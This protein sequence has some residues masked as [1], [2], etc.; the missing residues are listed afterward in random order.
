MPTSAGGRSSCTRGGNWPDLSLTTQWACREAFAAW[1]P[2][3]GVPFSYAVAVGYVLTD[4]ADKG[5]AAYRL[6]GQELG[7]NAALNPKVDLPRQAAL[8][9]QAQYILVE[10]KFNC[11]FPARC[12]LTRLLALERTLDTLVWQLLASVICPGFQQLNEVVMEGASS[13]VYK[14]ITSAGYTI[15]TIVALGHAALRPLEV[16]DW[17]DGVGQS[18][19]CYLLKT[20]S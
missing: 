15:H 8:N 3:W 9:D 13:K 12:R 1:L 17:T 10:G 6:A 2:Y 14:S 11:G 19:T 5:R 4:T 16:S 18:D 7:A 20:M